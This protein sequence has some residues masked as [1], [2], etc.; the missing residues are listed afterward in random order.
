MIKKVLFTTSLFG[1]A[2]TLFAQQGDGPQLIIRADDMGAFHST[3][4]ACMESA[5]KGIVQSVEVMPVASWYPEAVKMLQANP[6]IDVGLHLVFTSE[7]ENVK[8]RPLTVCKGLTDEH[9]YF[10]PMMKP[11]AAYLGLSV[12][13]NQHLWDF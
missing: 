9:G 8:W 4:M 10:F 11:H 7:W 1:I 2:T 5:L 3:N 13:E 6:T 12:M